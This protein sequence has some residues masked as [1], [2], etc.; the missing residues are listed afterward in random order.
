MEPEASEKKFQTDLELESQSED[1]PKKARLSK[2]EKKSLKLEKRRLKVLEN[3]PLER[4]RRKEKKKERNKA[5]ALAAVSEGEIE[6][7]TVA[8]PKKRKL[9]DITMSRNSL[10]LD[11]EFDND[12]TEAVCHSFRS[13]ILLLHSAF[14]V[15]QD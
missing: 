10:I 9:E 15:S 8:K 14:L 11:L 12:M 2:K 1:T 5:N 3:R 7:N 4:A 6:R 13:S